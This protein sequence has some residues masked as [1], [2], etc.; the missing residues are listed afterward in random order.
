[1]PNYLTPGVHEESITLGTRWTV[2]EPND[3]T[4][5]GNIRRDVGAFLLRL[6][7]DGALS[8]SGQPQRKNVSILML[9]MDGMTEMLR[10]NLAIA[11]LVLAFESLN[12][13]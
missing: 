12:R 7:R 4:L 5:W 6:W 13:G 10:Y 11:R 3:P 2:F 8:M 1:M 9:G